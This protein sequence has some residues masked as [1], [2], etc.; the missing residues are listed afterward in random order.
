MLFL[1]LASGPLAAQQNLDAD[2]KRE[3]LAIWARLK[4]MTQSEFQELMAKA[5]SGD[6]QAFKPCNP[7]C[8][9]RC[10]FR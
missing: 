6:A 4:L 10:T 1:I 9:L 5:Q 8:K 2:S 7:R 3:G